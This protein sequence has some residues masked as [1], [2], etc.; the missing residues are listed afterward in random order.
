VIAAYRD[1]LLNDT[2]PFWTRHCVDRE[3][4]GFMMALDRDGQVIDTDKGMWQQ[5]RFT[6]LLGELYNTVEPREEWL[7]LARHGI[8]FIERHGFDPADGRMWFHVTREGRPIR[9]R[10]YAFT[11]SFAA[12]CLAEFAKATGSD[13]YASKARAA[14]DAF[15]DHV[16]PA[17][18]TD[19][20]PTKGLGPPMILLTTLQELRQ[21]IGLDVNARIDRIIDEIRQDFLKPDLRCLME[22]V[23]PDG[24][25]IDHYDGRMLNPG[26]AIECAWFILQEARLRGDASLLQLGCD[27]LDWMYERGWDREH[28]GLL[29]F[30]DLQGLPVQEYWHD[31][32]FWWPHNELINASLLASVLTGEPRFAEMHTRAHDWAHRYFPDPE[33]GEWY[34]Y[35]HRDGSIASRAKGNLWKGPFHMPRMQLACWQLLKSTGESA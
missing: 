27:I 8:N 18:C 3:H 22:T 20:R 5:C 32:K 4:G 25:I 9:K 26:H 14:C 10:R 19:A 1:G 6:W 33:H 15:A 2:L 17:K 34:G 35:L 23:A 21:S 24:G 13:E 29:Y 12:I 31:M 30:V 28:G 16:V 7:E 11:E